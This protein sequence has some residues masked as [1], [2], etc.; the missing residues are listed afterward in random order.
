MSQHD[1][2]PNSSHSGSFESMLRQRLASLEPIRF[3][4]IDDSALHAGHAG[5]KSGGGHYRL[6]IVSSA[7]TGKSTVA[8]H[9]M[10][11]SAL[12]DLMRDKIHA[13]SIQSLA[14]NEV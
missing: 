2:A 13:I 4:L 6:L 3:E 7:F 1:V 12:G 11:Y 5:A 8:R 14:A 9:R 10:I